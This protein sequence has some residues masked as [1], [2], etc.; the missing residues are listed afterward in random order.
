MIEMIQN[1]YTCNIKERNLRRIHYMSEVVSG[2]ASCLNRLN[3]VGILKAVGIVH[4]SSFYLGLEEY[5]DGDKNSFFYRVLCYSSGLIPATPSDED[6]DSCDPGLLFAME[7]FEKVRIELGCR[8][9]LLEKYFRM[10]N[11]YESLICYYESRGTSDVNYE[12]KAKEIIS[13]IRDSNVV[14][15]FPTAS[16]KD[17]LIV[18]FLPERDSV[19]RF[20][21]TT[22][23]GEE[24]GMIV[25]DNRQKT[26]KWTGNFDIEKDVVGKVSEELCAWIKSGCDWHG[27]YYVCLVCIRNEDEDYLLK[28]ELKMLDQEDVRILLNTIG[29]AASLS[30]GYM[31]VKVSFSG[32]VPSWKRKSSHYAYIFT[33]GVSKKEVEV[34]GDDEFTVEAN[35]SD[36]EDAAKGILI[37]Y[38]GDD[39]YYTY[40]EVV[41]V[42]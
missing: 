7:V 10:K 11:L 28:H 35:L 9:F 20:R 42:D 12:S 15:G 33:I 41:L 5:L 32:L 25:F 14:T 40:V 1:Y 22:F 38:L 31:S 2:M 36:I 3:G 6:F 19:K 37:E 34:T 16:E 39:A 17:Y 4:D 27:F 29:R 26:V 30:S 21:V 23:C 8:G 24:L 18:K 13:V